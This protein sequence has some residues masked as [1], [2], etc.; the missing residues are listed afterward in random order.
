[1][2]DCA[3][4]SPFSEAAHF[5]DFRAPYASQALTYVRDAIGI[6]QSSRALDLGCGPGTIAIPLSQMVGQVLAID[7]SEDM[8]NQG[9]IRS[10]RAN[11]RNI[12]WL[13]A[14]AEEVTE[15]LGIFD[16]VTMGQS[17]HWMDR[18]TVLRRLAAII[19]S[20]GGLA[21]ISPGQRRPQESWEALAGEVI[22]RYLGPRARHPQMN[23]EPENEPSLLRSGTFSRFTVREFSM[24]F[25]RDVPSII[26]NIYSMSTSPRSAFGD[27]AALF[28][29][30]L[31]ESLL[32]LNPSGV[33]KEQL[34]T[35]VVIA[36]KQ[37]MEFIG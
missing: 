22:V 21:L 23:P 18:D 2:A 14:R 8:L 19:A 25:E 17:F 10:A 31:T 35:Q 20:D 29:R 4:D 33:F 3:F 12:A 1:M 6:G 30:D 28:E 16:V 26:G 5:Y 15:A 9:R 24:Q 7:P 34:E 37:D 36:R 11:C 27:R 13:C 32:R